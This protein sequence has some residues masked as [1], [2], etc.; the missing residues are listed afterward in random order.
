MK[1]LFIIGSCVLLLG[2]CASNKEVTKAYK[3]RQAYDYYQDANIK[4]NEA[5]IDLLEE[6]I[7]K[8]EK[9]NEND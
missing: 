9:Q 6:R 7:E 2:S 5:Y 1:K 3:L 4:H 8:L